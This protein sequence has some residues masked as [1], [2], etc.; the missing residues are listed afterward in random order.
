MT[1][2]NVLGVNVTI[3]P[4][5]WAF[6]VRVGENERKVAELESAQHTAASW[7]T[8]ALGFTLDDLDSYNDQL[9]KSWEAVK[10]AFPG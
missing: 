4:T 9:A 7:L 1:T 3:H 6:I 8:K 2:K 5:A 10:D